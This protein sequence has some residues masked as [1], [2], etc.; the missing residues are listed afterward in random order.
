MMPQEI[1]L[2]INFSYFHSVM[3]NGINVLSSSLYSITIFR[4]KKTLRVIMGSRSKE[5]CR[6]I[7]GEPSI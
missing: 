5:S 3:S 7:F 1:L 6:K 2:T 4:L